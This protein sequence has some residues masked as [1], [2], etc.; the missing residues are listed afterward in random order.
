MNILAKLLITTHTQIAESLSKKYFAIQRDSNENYTVYVKLDAEQNTIILALHNNFE[1][2]INFV[3]E[4]FEITKV[5]LIGNA[6][7][8]STLDIFPWD[9]MLPNAIMN[10]QN[11]VIFIEDSADRN[12]ELENFWVLF[13]G[14]CLTLDTPP[15]DEEELGAYREDYNAD[16]ID[17]TT[18]G[19]LNILKNIELASK[20][21]V[22]VSI[23]SELAIEHIEEVVDM[24]I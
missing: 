2:G 9:V 19:L 21:L 5:L 17:Y 20:T 13:N 16:I 4:N 12:Y 8:L 18:F 1:I 15:Q 6:Q 14:I 3:K 23:G 24:V 22:I 11:E 10:T 7:T